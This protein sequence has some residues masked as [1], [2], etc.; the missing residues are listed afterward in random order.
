MIDRIEVQE[1][2]NQI[3]VDHNL[4]V[5][6]VRDQNIYALGHIPGA[7]NFVPADHP[8]VLYDEG[9]ASSDSEIDETARLMEERGFQV[10]ILSGG[11]A[12][13]D[14]AGLPIETEQ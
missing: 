1:L 9:E 6:D 12:A 14:K 3:T 7:P 11:A 4:H 13:W 2:Y 8:I 10:R 5:I